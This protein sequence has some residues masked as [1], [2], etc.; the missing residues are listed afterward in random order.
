MGPGNASACSSM[1]K[2]ESCLIPPSIHS[3]ENCLNLQHTNPACLVCRQ[4]GSCAA[5]RK[6]KRERT[7]WSFHKQTHK[8]RHPLLTSGGGGGF[9]PRRHAFYLRV[10]AHFWG[11]FLLLPLI[12][13][14]LVRGHNRGGLLDA[15]TTSSEPKLRSCVARR[16]AAP[17]NF[18]SQKCNF[19]PSC[20]EPKIA[21]LH[22]RSR[23]C[24]HAPRMHSLVVN[25]EA[26]ARF[27]Y[28]SP[29]AFQDDATCQIFSFWP[30]TKTEPVHK[31]S[32]VYAHTQ[33]MRSL[34][35]NGEA[36]ARSP[37]AS[38]SKNG[39]L[40]ASCTATCTRVQT[41][42][43]TTTQRMLEH[44]HELG[45]HNVCHLLFPAWGGK[46][47]CKTLF[48]N[49]LALSKRETTTTTRKDKRNG[50]SPFLVPL[51][52][53][54]HN[55]SCCYAQTPNDHHS[56]ARPNKSH[57][58]SFCGDQC[59]WKLAQTLHTSVV[60]KA[61]ARCAPLMHNMVQR[62]WESSNALWCIV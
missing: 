1:S 16:R 34:E 52:F 21:P 41:Q 55:N 26:L 48:Q 9:M 61:P 22:N 47:S 35:V 10:S 15:F 27:V 39:F 60:C 29:L 54:V 11:I 45:A 17:P 50:D 59:K 14:C 24:A 2:A 4:T 7:G 6:E 25:D 31:R 46:F 44:A 33:R 56:R 8:A 58:K 38:Q 37:K 5:R 3:S 51:A 19:W 40:G 23:A 28:S 20:T 49:K 42:N 12:F 43:T 62:C 13:Q 30:N 53:V 36:L 32:R 57:P 18:Q